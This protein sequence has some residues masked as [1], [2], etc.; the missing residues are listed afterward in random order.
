MNCVT[1]IAEKF[2]RKY[3]TPEDVGEALKTNT[4]DIVRLAVLEVLGG[5]TDFGAEDSGLC[6]FVAYKGESD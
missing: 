1:V 5:Q 3:I 4:P 2:G 6:A